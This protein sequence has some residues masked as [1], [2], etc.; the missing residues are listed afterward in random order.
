MTYLGTL[1]ANWNE[2][3]SCLRIIQFVMSITMKT[4]RRHTHHSLVSL[5]ISRQYLLH[6]STRYWYC[7]LVSSIYICFIATETEAKCCGYKVSLMVNVWVGNLENIISRYKHAVYKVVNV[8]QIC[9][10]SKNILSFVNKSEHS[11]YWFQGRGRILCYAMHSL[12]H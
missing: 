2:Y 3:S 6:Q 1:S 8:W 4:Q 5:L 12:C 10:L 9:K 11:S 7:Q